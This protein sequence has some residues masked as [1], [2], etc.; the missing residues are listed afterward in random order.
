MRV[1]RS[2]R[3]HNGR[4]EYQINEEVKTHVQMTLRTQVRSLSRLCLHAIRVF[5]WRQ[6]QLKKFRY[7]A[8][9]SALQGFCFLF[10]L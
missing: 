9:I 3:S 8:S 1:P 7:A 4:D 2:I 5:L 10:I 6:I